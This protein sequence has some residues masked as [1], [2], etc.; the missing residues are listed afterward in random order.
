MQ[1]NKATKHSDP[2]RIWRYGICFIVVWSLFIFGSL[3]WKFRTE[4]E[5][6]MK[7]AKIEARSAFEKD[8]L[9][10]RW[11][12]AH[13]GL[14]VPITKDTM[15]NPYLDV[16]GREIQTLS[17]V[18]LTKI[19]PAYMT[20]QVYEIAMRTQ[21]VQGHITSLNPIRPQNAPDEWETEA[22]KTFEKGSEEV[23]SMEII[24]NQEYLR[25]MRPLETEKSCLKCHAKQGYKVG[26]IRGGISV[27]VPLKHLVAVEKANFIT[28][29]IIDGLLWILGVIGIIL[30][31][32]LLHRQISFRLQAEAKLR[33]GEKLEGIIEM[34]GA[35]CH[36]MNQPLQIISG[37]SELLM[38]TI[39]EK[40]PNHAK[41]KKIK[42]QT[43]RMGKITKKLMKITRN[44]TQSYPE[45]RIDNIDKSSNQKD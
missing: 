27:A 32:F 9:F 15:P 18:T 14:Y 20:R 22:L 11:N 26:D 43:D 42:A 41:I 12:A 25:L 8:V 34:A 5:G 16:P 3:S 45:C 35:V 31:M 36:D 2:P 4:K 24:N 37:Y 19:N 29:S 44:E 10:R 28:F 30:S 6:T 38:M 17:G 40:D 7:A 39:K 13:G 33:K 1:S 21:G 23:S